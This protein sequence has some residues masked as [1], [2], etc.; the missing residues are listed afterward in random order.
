VRVSSLH[1][2]STFL[3]IFFG[4]PND[5]FTQ[6]VVLVHT[7]TLKESRFFFFFFFLS[8]TFQHVFGAK[9]KWHYK[10]DDLLKGVQI[11]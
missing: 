3:Y 8:F 6:V 2:I 7:E 1:N 11:I 10:A 5:M 9:K 4:E